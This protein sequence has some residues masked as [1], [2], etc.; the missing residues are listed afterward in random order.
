MRIDIIHTE[1]EREVL[2][3]MEEKWRQH[4]EVQAQMSNLIRTYGLDQL[5][6]HET[7]A[8]TI[9][10]KRRVV[11]SDL[12]E[13]AHNDCVLEAREQPEN[14]VDL[15]RDQHPVRQPLRVQPQL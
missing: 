4:D 6:M 3:K 2:R 14:S 10:V 11:K 5:A 13:V 12:F 9:G 8:R 1:A 15:D 7:L